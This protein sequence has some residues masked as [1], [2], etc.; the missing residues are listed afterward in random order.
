MFDNF[1]KYDIKNIMLNMNFK[2]YNRIIDKHKIAYIIA[3]SKQ[4]G[5]SLSNNLIH[6]MENSI[7]KYNFYIPFTH[8]YY[9][10][11]YQSRF[12]YDYLS[13]EYIKQT[14]NYV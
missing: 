9:N 5:L 10:E 7:G 1:D 6:K 3:L 11:N 12:N 14:R 2:E 4:I 8:Y 13:K